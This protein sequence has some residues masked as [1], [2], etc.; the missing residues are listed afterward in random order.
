MPR[1]SAFVRF[2]TK[3]RF[4]W[5]VIMPAK[6]IRA[7]TFSHELVEAALRHDTNARRT[8]TTRYSSG[9]VA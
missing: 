8:Q 3:A 6:V 5:L 7:L 2:K 4:L 1:V 9:A